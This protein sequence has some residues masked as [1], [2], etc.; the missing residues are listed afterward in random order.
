MTEASAAVSAHYTTGGLLERIRAGLQRAGIDPDRAGYEDLK[1]IDEFHIGGAEA[2]EALLEQAPLD[3]GMALLDIGSGIGGSAR[4]IAGRTGCDV[5]GLDLTEEF[6]ATATALT[7]TAG[8]SDRVRFR[9]GS[10]L[11]MPFADDSFDAASMLHVGMNIADKSGLMAE[12]ARVLRPGGHF[13][14]YEVMRT[15]EGAL[16]FPLP[17]SGTPGTSWVAA[18]QEYRDAARAAGFEIA[19]ERERR[20]YALDFFARMQARMAEGAPPLGPHLI[21]GETYRE[22]IANMVTNIRAGRIAP[23]EMILRLL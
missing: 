3:A 4:L 7:G 23:V 17:W 14:V 1:P 9:V 13:L 10:A 12:A 19:A 8:L 16:S 18:P 15:G 5:T 22:K 2:T 11:D 21:V 20:D 6:V